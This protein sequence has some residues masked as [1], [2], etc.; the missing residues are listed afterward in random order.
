MVDNF[1]VRYIYIYRNIEHM[2]IVYGVCIYSI[3]S[4]YIYIIIFVYLD[5]HI[6]L[7]FVY[8]CNIYF[9]AGVW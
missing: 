8:I 9:F 1:V 7:F 2:C 4:I 5:Y 3:R 6:C